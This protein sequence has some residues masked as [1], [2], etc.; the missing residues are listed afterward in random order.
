MS[1]ER[2]LRPHMH[3]VHGDC[4]DKEQCNKPDQKNTLV[5]KDHMSRKD[6]KHDTMATILHNICSLQAMSSSHRST[7]TTPN[8]RIYYIICYPH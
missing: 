1:T 2:A 6:T 5:E 8:T 7:T 3:I 4:C